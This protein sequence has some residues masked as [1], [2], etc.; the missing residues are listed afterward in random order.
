M[1]LAPYQSAYAVSSMAAKPGRCWPELSQTKTEPWLS[2]RPEV[3]IANR[4][5]RARD[6]MMQWCTS[7]VQSKPHATRQQHSIRQEM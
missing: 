2:M 6:S 7:A 4:D 3:T 5:A 1:S